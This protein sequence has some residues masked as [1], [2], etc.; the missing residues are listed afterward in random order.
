MNEQLAVGKSRTPQLLDT[1]ENG[2]VKDE[3][4]KAVAVDPPVF[5]TVKP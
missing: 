4:F 1:T 5:V 2:A 3:K